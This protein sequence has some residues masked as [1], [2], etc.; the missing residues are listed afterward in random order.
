MSMRVY[1][2]LFKDPQMINRIVDWVPN[3]WKLGNNLSID[4]LKMFAEQK[5]Y[6]EDPSSLFYDKRASNRLGDSTYHPA[7]NRWWGSGIILYSIMQF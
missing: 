4:Y 5:L 1:Q 3:S 7:C 2:E 6:Y